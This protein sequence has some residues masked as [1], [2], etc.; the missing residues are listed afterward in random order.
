MN[1]AE[2]Q[3]A[4]FRE[5]YLTVAEVAELL[6]LSVKRVRNQMSSGIFVE[7]VH[8]LRPRG[9]GPRFVRSRVEAWLRGSD[10]PR[11]DNIPMAR[12]SLRPRTARTFPSA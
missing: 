1:V 3:R 7:G 9:I 5:E 6:R 11:S 4:P 12:C 2:N 8:F 10:E